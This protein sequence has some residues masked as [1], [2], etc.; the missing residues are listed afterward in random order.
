MIDAM[1]SY[2]E[3]HIT[4][5]INIPAYKFTQEDIDKTKQEIKE[6]EATKEYYETVTVNE[7]YNEDLKGI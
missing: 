3:G 1:K 5:L 7:L 4:R 6:N 2:D